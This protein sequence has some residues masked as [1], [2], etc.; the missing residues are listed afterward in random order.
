MPGLGNVLGNQRND[1]PVEAED[2]QGLEE[3]ANDQAG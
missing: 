3:T 1:S 2:N